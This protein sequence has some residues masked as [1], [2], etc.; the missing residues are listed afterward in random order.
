MYERVSSYY[1]PLF[2]PCRLG[3]LS[4]QNATVAPILSG[5]PA[6]PSRQRREMDVPSGC[7]SMSSTALEVSIFSM[8]VVVSLL[9]PGHR[10]SQ[11]VFDR[12]MC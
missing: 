4:G 7:T 9:E 10:L 8:M 11:A 1:L 3:G 12:L 2:F 6:L 5:R